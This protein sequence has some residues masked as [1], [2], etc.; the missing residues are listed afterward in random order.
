MNSGTFQVSISV[1]A[2]PAVTG[3]LSFLMVFLTA[4]V[5]RLL[6]IVIPLVMLIALIKFASPDESDLSPQELERRKLPA[7]VL[8]PSVSPDLPVLPPV[9]DE[10]RAFYAAVRGAFE[11]RD[12][13]FLEKEALELRESE[14][15]FGD[16]SWK[17]SR[18]YEALEQRRGF[19][20]EDESYLADL[21]TL[22]EWEVAFPDSITQRIA[23]GGF[24]VSFAKRVR[25]NRP[26]STLSKDELRAIEQRLVAAEV[27][28]ISLGGF[29]EKDP[30]EAILA[31]RIG[32]M[33]G[34]EAERLEEVLEESGKR[35][36]DFQDGELVP[37]Q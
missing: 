13:A 28:L 37:S 15:V 25:G 5:R 35:F 11:E 6:F 36:P 22:E 2:L 14:E 16:G 26:V 27:V 34:W 33:A 18:F 4:L 8:E 32:K 12:F 9:P 30:N 20:K 10:V 24:L 3:K 19:E 21:E 17:I 1:V 7:L 29:R 31:L 23:L